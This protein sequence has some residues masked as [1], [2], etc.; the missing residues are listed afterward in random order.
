MSRQHYS[1]HA[2]MSKRKQRTLLDHVAAAGAFVYPL[3]GLPQLLLVFR[4]EINGV[5]VMSWLGFLLFSLLFFAYGV[6][7]RI[8]PIMITN[9]L[10]IVIDAMIVTGLIVRRMM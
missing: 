5:S 9:L 7:H 3:T 4:G 10:W 6:V 8:K 2:H 1:F